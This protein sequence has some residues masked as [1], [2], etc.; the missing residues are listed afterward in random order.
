MLSHFS[1][2]RLFVFSWTVARQVSL[3][4]GFFRQEYWSGLP[5]PPPGD[6]PEPELKPVSPAS[7]ALQVGSFLLCHWESPL[8]LCPNFPPL[9]RHQ[10]YWNKAYPNCPILI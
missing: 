5:C 9:Y 1:C 8:G 4:M 10:S 2:V 3:S 6:L 7:S